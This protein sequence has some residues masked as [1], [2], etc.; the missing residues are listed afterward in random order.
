VSAPSPTLDGLCDTRFARV[1]EAF[2]TNF[3]ER[4]DVGAAIAVTVG[5]QPVVDLWGGWLDEARTRPW[6]RDSIL[7]VWSVGKAVTAVCLLRLIEQGRVELEAPVARYWPEFA[8][9][10]KAELP[11]RLLFNHQ[12]GLPAIAKPLEPGTQLLDWGAMAGAL[13]EQ[14]PWWEPGTRFGYHTNTFGFL[15]GEIV[16]RVD[17]RSLGAYLREEIAEPIGI[18]F[19]IG[20][21]PEQ[22]ARVAD[23]V[24]YQRDPNE[25]SDR[26]WLELDPA[27][28][29]GIDLA[30]VL[31]YRNPPTLPGAQTNS[32]VWRAAE[33]PSTN[34]HSN[35][36]ALA[37]LYGGL[38]TGG[39]VDGRHLLL[40]P[41]T[42]ARANT[43]ESDGEDA[44]LGRPNR[45]GLG[46]QL[47]I[48][49]VRPLGPGAHSFGHY[50]NGGVV[51]F[52]DP[53]AGIGFGFVCNQS[54]RSWR[55]P[56]NIALI[57]AVYASL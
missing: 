36:R 30:R 25:P 38:A 13:A 34:G 12:A 14:Q 23:W 15:L 50:G 9:A 22:D 52:A 16:R 3:R 11:V 26:P 57:D 28:L 56:R 6:T 20:F 27:T 10:G 18:D 37:R 32:R 51:G 41:E 1:R 39:K 48:P 24:N 31:A 7:N 44:I 49:G 55:D 29:S 2:D 5:G 4:G 46:F 8:Q 17:G 47:T 45:F 43:I 19:L 35:A 21:G 54:G 53:D 33:F 42:I 40:T